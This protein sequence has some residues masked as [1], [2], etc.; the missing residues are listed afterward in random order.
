MA[1]PQNKNLCLSV[2]EQLRGAAML[3]PTEL[4]ELMRFA[5]TLL[6][7]AAGAPATV[8]QS[9]TVDG[10]AGV[11]VQQTE[12][13]AE[14]VAQEQLLAESVKELRRQVAHLRMWSRMLRAFDEGMG[15][16][17][18]GGGAARV[19]RGLSDEDADEA[20]SLI[21]ELRGL[22]REVRAAAQRR[23]RPDR[24]GGLFEGADAT[25]RADQGRPAGPSDE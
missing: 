12:Q 7:E 18:A 3:A 17:P 23:A 16:D 8:L 24:L 4:A 19:A 14:A 11:T 21:E 22:R 9:Q 1:I 25:P 15:I 13:P 5:S 2:A 10:P 6:A 20:V